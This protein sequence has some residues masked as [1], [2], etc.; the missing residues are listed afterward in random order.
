MMP[1]W[2]TTRFLR[3]MR[4]RVDL[5]RHAVG[6]PAGVADPRRSPDWIVFQKLFQIGELA[7]DRRRSI[8]PLSKVAM[9]AES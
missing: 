1:L 9:P 2:T 6:G 8:W 4:V 7:L 3:G 5:A